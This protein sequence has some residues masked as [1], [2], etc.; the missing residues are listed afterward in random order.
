MRDEE[1]GGF[2]CITFRMTSIIVPSRYST[3]PTILSPKVG[4]SGTPVNSYA[5]SLSCSILYIGRPIS[6]KRSFNFGFEGFTAM[7]R[8]VTTTS[9]QS[10]GVEIV[11]TSSTTIGIRFLRRGAT[12]IARFAPAAVSGCPPRAPIIIPSEEVRTFT[13]KFIS[14][15]VADKIITS[16]L[17]VTEP[18]VNGSAYISASI[19]I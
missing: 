9:I 1:K 16:R 8:S 13:L 19:S 7:P 15:S 6:I 5:I 10:P 14:T 2:Y 3:S 18:F 17:F 11:T 12:T 4:F